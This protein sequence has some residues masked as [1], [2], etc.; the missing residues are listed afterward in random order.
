MKKSTAM[1]IVLLM[2]CFIGCARTEN[3]TKESTGVTAA[4]P[5]TTTHAAQETE[6]AAMRITVT[7]NGKRFTAT[8][9]DTAAAKELYDLIRREGLTVSLSDYDGFEKVGAL[10][11]TLTANDEHTTTKAGDIVLYQSN[12]IVLFYGSNS[13]S[14]TRLG[15]IDD[16][17]GWEEALGSGNVTAEF[18][19]IE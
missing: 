3:P 19:A 17:R 8:L 11:H 14:Y 13:W 18:S 16:V 12:Q 9:E 1:V 4:M 7:V 10:G 5:S 15:R 2:L 6:D